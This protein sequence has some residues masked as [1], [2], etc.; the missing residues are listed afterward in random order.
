M[1]KNPF[2]MQ[3]VPGMLAGENE[4]SNKLEESMTIPQSIETPLSQ[5]IKWE[6]QEE[7]DAFREACRAANKGDWVDE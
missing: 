2:E 4:M 6:R 1:P 5:L 7:Q 3:D